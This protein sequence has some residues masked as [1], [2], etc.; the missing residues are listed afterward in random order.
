M[1]SLKDMGMHLIDTLL[2]ILVGDGMTPHDYCCVWLV[3]RL[4]SVDDGDLI[5][6][7]ET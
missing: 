3:G 6:H 4:V 5:G 2:E 7:V 1:I